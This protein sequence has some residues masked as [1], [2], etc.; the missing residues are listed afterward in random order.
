MRVAY[1]IV[2]TL[3]QFDLPE[4]EDDTSSLQEDGAVPHYGCQHRQ[5]VTVSVQ[6]NCR[7]VLGP[8]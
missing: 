6:Y 3:E 1:D 8:M 7:A 4:L 2:N 5:Q